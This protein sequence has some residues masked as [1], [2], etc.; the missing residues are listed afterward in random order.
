MLST[1]SSITAR[2]LA[3]PPWLAWI[4]GSLEDNAKFVLSDLEKQADH[5]MEPSL[6]GVVLC[7]LGLVFCELSK[8]GASH[9]EETGTALQLGDDTF[10]FL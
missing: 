1:R 2:I 4:P 9:L 3:T 8:H 6:L 7:E 5:A 10:A